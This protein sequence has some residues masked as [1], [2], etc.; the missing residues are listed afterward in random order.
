[1]EDRSFSFFQTGFE[2]C[3]EQFEKA[4]L[5]PVGREEFPDLDKA[6]SSLSDEVYA[7]N[8]EPGAED[9]EDHSWIL[10]SGCSFHMYPQHIL[11]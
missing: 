11:V 3:K 5:L 9:K 8:Q 10:D 7:A 2:K 1:M 6:I 4:G